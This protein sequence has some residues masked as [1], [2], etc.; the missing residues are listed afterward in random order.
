MPPVLLALLVGLFV[1]AVVGMLG[2]GGGLLSMPILVYAL[3][4]DPHSAVA[5]SLV[6]VAASASMSLIPHARRRNVGW[7]DGALF[8]VLGILGTVVASRLAAYVPSDLLMALFAVLLLLVAAT[9]ARRTL[10][11]SR[12]LEEQ[13]PAPRH[14]L[15]ALILTASATGILTGLFGVGGGF[16]V[17]PALLIVLR[18]DI[19]RAVGTSLFVVLIN[20]LVGLA[21]RI[22]TPVTIDWPVIISFAATS[23]LAG[24]FAARISAGVRPKILNLLFATLLLA[25][26]LVTGIQSVPELLG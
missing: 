17:V 7:R 22:G 14:R 1:G 26:A 2:A 24:F 15:L 5:S 10:R 18:T 3:G 19:R 23:M 16:I 8:G 9:M 20:S 13:A 11:P 4:I 21:A 12:T 25:V 6:I